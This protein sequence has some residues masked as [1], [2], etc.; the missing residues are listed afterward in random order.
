MELLDRLLTDDDLTLKLLRS[1]KQGPEALF[2]LMSD[3]GPLEAATTGPLAP[4]FDYESELAAAKETFAA[5]AERLNLPNP[6]EM[7]PP[8]ENV[9][10]V[11]AKIVREAD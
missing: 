4:L 7:G 11:S 8:L 1:G 5:L 9:R 6:P 3:Q 2:H 10:I